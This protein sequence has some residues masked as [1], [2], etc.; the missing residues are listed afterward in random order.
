MFSPYR[1]NRYLLI[2][3][4]HCRSV[5][6]A[7]AL[8]HEKLLYLHDLVDKHN[9]ILSSYTCVKYEYWYQHVRMRSCYTIYYI[10]WYRKYT[11]LFKSG[12]FLYKSTYT[13]TANSWTIIYDDNNKFSTQ[14][15]ICISILYII[16]VYYCH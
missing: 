12:C 3:S 6:V 11:Y 9:R 4:S 15:S 13:Y 14:L 8:L 16:D 10:I 7:Y 1:Y 2:F 5:V